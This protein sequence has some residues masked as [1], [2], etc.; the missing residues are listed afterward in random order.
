M[1]EYLHALRAIFA[2]WQ[3]GEKLDFRGEHYQFTRMQ[4]FFDPGPLEHPDIPI[5]L[6]AIG[7]L[8]TGLAGEA[9]DGMTTHPTNTAPRYIREVIHPRLEKGAARGRRSQGAVKL[10]VGP[11]T[12]T[13]RDAAAVAAQRERQREML[14]FLYSTPAYFPSLELFG[15]R[16]RGERL[17]A[18]TR[19]GRWDDMK[20]IVDD[21]ML[22][23]LLPCAPY[24][25]IAD[26]LKEWYGELAPRITFPMPED[27]SDDAEVATVIAALKR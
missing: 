24:S 4:P 2:C 7:P 13:G 23:T 16:E 17:H 27:P 15:W 11:L 18:L 25:E 26:L 6:G 5:T 12:A 14:T 1:R 8:M 3:H 21:E 19:E 20:G 10:M 22:D 9:A